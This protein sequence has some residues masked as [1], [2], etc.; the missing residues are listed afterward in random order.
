MKGKITAIGYLG[1]G[2]GTVF[3]FESCSL[4]DKLP[5]SGDSGL[6]AALVG[7]GLVI[8]CYLTGFAS[9]SNHILAEAIG[10]R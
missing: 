8:G 9:E 2:L 5:A 10:Q 1:I 7:F 3:L 4:I 6:V